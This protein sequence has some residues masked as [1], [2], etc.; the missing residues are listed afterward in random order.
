MNPTAASCAGPDPNRRDFF[1]AAEVR[2]RQ[3][4][5]EPAPPDNVHGPPSSP[6]FEM[7]LSRHAIAA[8][9]AIAFCVPAFA[10]PFAYVSNQASGTVSV[11]DTAKDEVVRTLSGEG[12]LGKNVRGIVADHTGKT[13]F[14]VDAKGGKIDALDVATDKLKAQIP[15][16][17]SPEGLGLSANGELLA[18]CLEDDNAVAL[19]DVKTLKVTKHIALAGKNP[20][21][22]VFSPDGALLLASNENSNDIDVVDLKAGVTRGTVK[23]SGHPRGIAFL[24][25][26]HTAYVAAET[27]NAVDVVDADKR[28]VVR[29]IASALRSAG[30]IASADGKTVYIANGGAGSVS[31]ID[32]A[33]NKVVAD[34][35]VGKRPWNMALT[36][37]GKKLYVANGRSNSVSVIDTATRKPVREIAVGE[38]PWGVAIP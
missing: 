27:A 31:V 24:P 19:V 5:S 18:A 9:L 23:S 37:D 12:K 14:V 28:S 26:T 32:I 38:L 7:R 29:T 25:G 2:I 33:T 20:E 22:C 1:P 15:V 13:L 11:I 30:A 4:L 21:H 17:D 8:A 10:A 36:R 3:D 6:E 16:G 35:P 34:I